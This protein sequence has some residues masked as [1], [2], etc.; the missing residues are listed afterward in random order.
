[1]ALGLEKYKVGYELH[2]GEKELAYFCILEYVPVY[3]Y[4]FSQIAVECTPKIKVV[5]FRN[6][7]WVR[8]AWSDNLCQSIHIHGK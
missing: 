4:I 3:G 6:D 2:C 8:T 1:M 5:R 7:S